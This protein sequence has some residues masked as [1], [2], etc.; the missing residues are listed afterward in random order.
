MAD[1]E[2]FETAVEVREVDLSSGERAEAIRQVQEF[3][4][5]EVLERVTREIGDESYQVDAVQMS[6]PFELGGA[7]YVSASVVVW[8]EGPGQR[9]WPSLP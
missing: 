3:C 2:R 8:V 1:S 4:L 7:W 9:L 5:R 6:G